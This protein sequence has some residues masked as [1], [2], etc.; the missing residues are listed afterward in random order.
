VKY[1]AFRLFCSENEDPKRDATT[2]PS[3]KTRAAKPSGQEVEPVVKSRK[4][5]KTPVKKVIIT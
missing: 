4:A 3:A 5:Q 2:A 1:L